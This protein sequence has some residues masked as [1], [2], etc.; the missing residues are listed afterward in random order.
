MKPI[1][2]IL[3][4]GI[5]SR[6]G[7]LKQLDS[8]SKENDTILDFSLYDAIQ[9]GFGKV[10][11]VIRKCLEM[12]FK[13]MF[14]DKLKNKIKVEY[15]IQEID[16]VPYFY[17]D[18]LKFRTKPWG[19]AHA[20][21]TAK[22]K[23]NTNFA[24]VNA[25]D[26]YGKDAFNIM[27]NY[28][29]N[30]DV[31]STNF[32]MIGYILKN[33]LS[34]YGYVSRGECKVDDNKNLITITERTKIKKIKNNIYYIKNDEKVYISENTI[35][36]M[37]FLGFTPEY[38]KLSDKMFVDFLEKNIDNLKSE[39]FLPL[40]VNHIVDRDLGNIKVLK[41]TSKWFGVTYKEDKQHV[42]QEIKKLKNDKTYPLI[43]F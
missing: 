4:A 29:I 5:G 31:K 23:I 7:G 9:A 12:K 24:V 8:F 41:S 37:N 20:L 22:D 2:V 43:L 39:F 25:D 33:T 16:N 26:F 34:K 21:M 32:T 15:V 35:V 11:F 1:L 42:V 28:L 3:A 6:Y 17:K 18:R 27:A 19:T 38:F 36:S 30:T 14:D 13:C 40:V 10:I